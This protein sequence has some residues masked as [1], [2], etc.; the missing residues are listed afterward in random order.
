MNIIVS[1]NERKKVRDAL[2]EMAV[3]ANLPYDFQLMTNRGLVALERKKFPSD[4]LASV[5]DS[6]LAKECASMRADSGYRILI[7]EGK[8][9]YTKDGYLKRG[10]KVTRWT[11]SGIRNLMRSIRY[12]EATDIEFSDNIEGTVEILKEL[13]EYFDADTHLSIRSRRKFTSCTQFVPTYEER[14]NFFLQGLPSINIIRARALA[15]VFKSPMEVFSASVEDL[16]SIKGIGGKTATS[17]YNFLR[18]IDGN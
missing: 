16:K 15:G 12:V 5:E 18:G 6:R 9:K 10:T 7:V 1:S 8:G 4:F 3:V 17:I 13:Q 2:G 11:K 14:F